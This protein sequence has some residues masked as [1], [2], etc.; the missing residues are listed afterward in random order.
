MFLPRINKKEIKFLVLWSAFIITLILL[1]HLYGYIVSPQGKQFTNLISA[2]PEDTNSYFAWINQAK[3]GHFLFEDIYTTESHERSFFHPVFLVIGFASKLFHIPTIILWYIGQIVA[4]LFLCISVY[5]FLSFFI[6]KGGQRILAFILATTSA[7]LGWI[8]GFVSVDTWMP[9][10][11]IFQSMSWPFL[12]PIAI[13]LMLWIFLFF[14]E[15]LKQG[16]L[17]YIFYAG[18]LTLLLTF[19]HPY[20]VVTVY[21]VLGIYTLYLTFQQKLI[22]KHFLRFFIFLLI[23][24]PAP[25]YNFY[26]ISKNPVFHQ[27]AQ[28]KTLSPSLYSYLL[29]FGILIPLAIWGIARILRE[30]RKNL[31]FLLIWILVGFVLVY[32]PFNFQRRLIMGMQIPLVI[33]ASIPLFKL[34]APL[35]GKVLTFPKA[36]V[37]AY[38]LLILSATN[39]NYLG[40]FF[41]VLKRGGYPWYLQKE[42]VEAMKWLDENSSSGEIIFSSYETG[43]FIPRFSGNKTF[44]GHWDQT[45][46]LAQ[47]EEIVDDFFSSQPFPYELKRLSEFYGIKYIF[48][49][50]YEKAIAKDIPVSKRK[51]IETFLSASANKVFDNGIVKIFKYAQ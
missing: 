35:K 40:N 7:G 47:K 17:K 1:P 26:L 42:V 5:L 45:I 16:K 51:A 9:E 2:Y 13:A 22:R 11:I 4:N 38:L 21:S 37:L 49:G 8:F 24:L 10:A 25:L 12:F 50:P 19:I 3:E 6:K 28:S 43:N 39:I 44:I 30:R 20:D 14:L 34:V 33:L 15:A 18:L 36:I 48:F 41:L 29:G 32:L 46:H 23:S 27:W 31:Y